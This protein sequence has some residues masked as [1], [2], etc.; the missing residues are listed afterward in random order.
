MGADREP[1][2]G[3]RPRPP[4]TGVEDRPRGL[5][6]LPN[7]SSMRY[8]T[9]S[10]KAHIVSKPGISCQFLWTEI[11]YGPL[12]Q[13]KWEHIEG[14][15]VNG[16]RQLLLIAL[17]FL[18][19]ASGVACGDSEPSPTP[20]LALAPSPAPTPAPTLDATPTPTAATQTPAATPPSCPE[21]TAVHLIPSTIIALPAPS[22]PTIDT[23][24]NPDSASAS[25]RGILEKMENVLKNITDVNSARAA[26]PEWRALGEKSAKLSAEIEAMTDSDRALTEGN[27]EKDE[28]LNRLSHRLGLESQRVFSDP[29]MALA[30]SSLAEQVDAVVRPV[31]DSGLGIPH[32]IFR[33]FEEVSNDEVQ[34]SLQYAP[35]D[36]SGITSDFELICRMTSIIDA[37]D[38]NVLTRDR[39]EAGLFIAFDGD[40][41]GVTIK[42]GVLRFS[43]DGIV[44]LGLALER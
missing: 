40:I 7:L 23:P 30:L 3:A 18:L 19:A 43:L 29:Q 26:A 8:S 42:E 21:S 28:Q 9:A 15:G 13:L 12:L 35:T 14:V 11:E 16:M 25:F 1:P 31:I 38:G 41:G 44:T 20:T 17:F 5:L 37:L 32:R 34:V 4:A 10:T 39:N 22:R 27:I 2:V 24:L 36:L 6:Q 33:T